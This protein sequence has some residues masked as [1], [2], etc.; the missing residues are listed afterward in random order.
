MSKALEESEG[1][2]FVR[3]LSLLTEEALLAPKRT[4][5]FLL[6]SLRNERQ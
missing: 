5:K 6:R 1:H 2:S 3:P 4:P